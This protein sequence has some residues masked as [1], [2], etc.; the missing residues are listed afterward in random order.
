MVRMSRTALLLACVLSASMLAGSAGAGPFEILR[1]SQDG[2]EL[3]LRLPPPPLIESGPDG[4]FVS[5]RAPG[6]A[7]IDEPGNPALPFAA[8]LLAVPDGAVV[9]VA[10]L[11][12]DAVDLGRVWLPAAGYGA[13]ASPAAAVPTQAA[14]FLP[15]DVVVTEYVGI[16]RG[17]AAHSLRVYPLSYDGDRLMG[18][19]RLRIRVRFRGGRA[20]AGGAKT[21][22]SPATAAGQT[23]YAPFLNAAQAPAMSRVS[24]APA[25]KTA[26]TAEW[27]DPSRPWVKLWVKDDGIYRVTGA[28][29]QSRQVD[30][31]SVDPTTL[32][33]FYLG[34]ELP[35]FVSGEEEDGRFDPSD[36]LLFHG[37]FRRDEIDGREKD[38]D[39]LY[40]RR[41]TYWLTWGSEPGRRF[42][43]R[44][45]PPVNDYPL[46][47]WFAATAHFEQDLWYQSLPDAPP[48]NDRD[49]WFWMLRQPVTSLSAVRR[50]SQT[51]FGDLPAASLRGNYTT[52]VRVAL[53]GSSSLQHHTFLEL[54]RNEIDESR[55]E[56]QGELVV[57]REIPSSFLDPVRNRIL[58]Q[59]LADSAPFDL[60]FF[61]WFEIDYHR[62][63]VAGPG[64][65]AFDE[66]AT[67]GRR[68]TVT[69]L[70]HPRVEL[71]DMANAI[72][73]VDMEVSSVGKAWWVTF[74]DRSNTP[75]AYAIA[76]SL[77]F[78]QP[79]GLVDAPSDLRSSANAA[80]YIIIHHPRFRAAAQTLADHRATVSGLTVKLVETDDIYDEFS[81]GRFTN[82]AVQDFI[83]HAYHNWQGRPA[84][85]L[86]LG[87]ETYDYRMIL[88]GPPP[89]FVP[90]LYY[91]ARD[92]GNSPSDYLYALVDGDDLLADLAIGR[93]AVTSS[94]EARGAVEK[95]IRYDLD[96]EPGDWR[97]R[98]IYLANWQEAGNFTKPHDAL[99]ERFTEPY[100]LVS[101]KIAN[102]D[103]SP[104][105]NE[106][107][108]KFVDALNDGALLVN[109]AGHGSAGNMQ[110]IFAL[111]F[112]D[113]GYLGQVDN[114]RRL[115]LVLGLSCLNGMFVDP[116]AACLGQVFTSMADGG[117][118]AYI[119][120]SALSRIAQN[121]LLAEI[122]YEQ[123]FDEGR[124]AFGPVLNTAKARVL[125]AHPSYVVAAKTMQLFGDPAQELA[126]PTAA[127]YQPV[128]LE[129]TSPQVLSH[130]E[131]RVE[132]SVRNN[133][134]RTADS[135][136]LVILGRS[137]LGSAAPDTLFAGLLG[138]FAG[139]RTFSFDWPVGDR[140]GAYTLE[141]LLDPDDRI[142]E[143]DEL[144]NEAQLGL[145]ILEPLLPVP[146]FPADGAVVPAEQVTLE[147]LVP[148]TL[149]PQGG[150]SF[151]CEFA[152]STTPEFD[153]E[154]ETLLAA[155]VRAEGGS[156]LFQPAVLPVLSTANPTSQSA[157]LLSGTL[158]F[159]R[160][161]LLDG[162]NPG[163]WTET[164]T[165][166]ALSGLA[167]PAPDDTRIWRQAGLQLLRGDTEDLELAGD[168]GLRVSTYSSPFRPS[169][170]TRE[171][172][173]TVR[174]L[175]GAGVLATDGTYL[176]AKRWFNDDTTVYPGTD[177]FTRIG[178]G[179][180]GTVEDHNYGLLAD[181]TT[182]GISA[183]YH[184]D[185]FIYSESGHGFELER[186][187][188]ETG[189]LDTVAVPDGLLEWKLGRVDSLGHSLITSDGRYIYNV[190]MSSPIGSRTGWGVRV[191]DP[192]D[193]WRLVREFVSPPTETGFT[194][195]WT[196]GIVA[197]GERLYF[198]E[199]SGRRRIR[200]VDAEDGRFLDEWTSDQD[201]TRI[202]SGQYD[203]IN[204]KV[205]LG[206]LK[207]SAIFRYTGLGRIE[208]GSVVS[209]PVGPARAWQS[210]S[211]DGDEP[212]LLQTELAIEGEDGR[213]QTLIGFHDLPT[214]LPPVD[215]S[216]IDAAVHPTIRLRAR[217]AD[218]TGTARLDAW[219]LRFQP[220]A[221]LEV[222]DAD[223][224]M[225]SSGLQVRAAVRNLSPFPVTAAELV[226]ERTDG[227]VVSRRPL[228]ALDRGG[229]RVVT[230]D[231][232]F[233][234]PVG[235]GLFAHLVTPGGPAGDR[236]EIPLLFEGRASLT[237]NLWPSHHTFASGDPLRRD[238]GIVISAPRVEAGRLL[239]AVDG[240]P[241]TV[242]PDSLEGGPDDRLRVVFRPLAQNGRH[243]LSVRLFSGPDEVGSREIVFAMADAL[244][245]G[246]VLLYPH[247][248]KERSDFTYA[249][250][251][252]AEVS[253]EIF[254]MGGRLV[255]T[256]GPMAQAAGFRRIEWDGRD[257][258]GQRLA[259]ST[260]FYRLRAVGTEGDSA[261]AR[262]PLIVLR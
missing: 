189:K 21:A 146:V 63:Y 108:R 188:P 56:G 24:P 183:T 102:P 168:G 60:V 230:V 213:W 64:Y 223:A 127:D 203:W 97:S 253:V 141:L 142:P 39:S 111:Q 126:L 95:I 219:E 7:R 175:G 226:V 200:M 158:L 248:L 211:I 180:N 67:D 73:F 57:E 9:E 173:F 182:A 238:Q 234:P 44:S 106:T 18:L 237:F 232:L 3:E 167:D 58:V 215:L 51:F 205:W 83:A 181:S 116:T 157:T 66:A 42:D 99:A 128:R 191:F 113:W 13:D 257:A 132:V 25:A 47:G 100:G 90:T 125:A 214:G 11:E 31:D 118:I 156:C 89:S 59:T 54:N 43:T 23:L 228:G 194:F 34:E 86:L 166:R 33:L 12:S 72:R 137:D 239:L 93:L 26:A 92:R 202:I 17:V 251:H 133:T 197:D 139:T 103:N 134:R 187:S 177:F 55:W 233:L 161:R 154:R 77:N 210:L 220:Q 236:L 171:S 164:L 152:L 222:S 149:D 75:S 129:V 131:V 19:Q 22:S 68:I 227:T 235:V 231:S 172:G 109:F 255:R 243:L 69:G 88:R 10:I 74:E 151:D 179:F 82:R 98:A 94:N 138:P 259:N 85:V 162:G 104:I 124:L 148:F 207:G 256:L 80:D 14:P 143:A 96:P 105:P 101:V 195:E 114:G 52:R 249:L 221:L 121:N 107:G 244:A 122:I 61:N 153:Q 247:P 119:S 201:T 155:L 5:F 218:T 40:G 165:F 192:A 169:S 163:P 120:A 27:Y 15:D 16:L 145:Q 2:L 242:E 178:T 20:P 209:D 70:S 196:D 174:G 190:S 65:L 112:P 224:R 170:R 8:A 71:F 212:G 193:D 204:N 241:L 159:W 38:F 32:Q 79:L 184:S 240:E 45:A 123:F 160:S 84:Y 198:I 53:N 258:G 29:L 91:H 199:F 78:R 186:I 246:H 35:L 50:G 250:S 217:L 147:A 30:T 261:E 36:Y 136:A 117:A 208:S 252:D 62:R 229:S 37:R 150:G 254:S 135:L 28:W 76:D 185:G 216:A 48:D 260:Y 81:F 1:S 262:G 87:D 110:F 4:A 46:S 49:H 130:T 140:A 115:P 245:L 206:D 225:D 144:N 41:N 6:F 176:Y